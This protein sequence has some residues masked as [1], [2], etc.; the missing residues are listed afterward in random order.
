MASRSTRDQLEDVADNCRQLG[1]RLDPVTQRVRSRFTVDT[2]ALAAL[3][4]S[5][6]LIILIDLF[7]R[8]GDLEL[9]YTDDG[10]YPLVAYETTYSR[11][12]GLSLHAASGDLWFQQMMFVLAG[13]FAVALILGYRT[14]LVAI[15]SF[16]LLFSL[17]ARNP[18]VLNG[19]DRLLRV[20]LLVALVTPLGERWSIDAL[21]RGTA[22]TTVTSV[23]TAALLAQPLAVFTTNAVLKH[24]G[25]TWYAG[26]A[27][28]IAFASDEMTILLGNH[29]TAYPT[30]LEVLTWAWV[31]LLAGSVVFLLVTTGR[32]RAFFALVYIGSFAGL[33]VSVSV[34][35]F[36]LVLTA[37]VFPFLSTPFWDTLTRLVP[38][39]LLE[40]R[41]SAAVLGPL[42]RSPLERRLLASVR[43]RGHDSAASF[44]VEFGRSLLTVV[45][46]LLLVWILLF[47]VAH[48]TDVEVP[49]GLDYDQLDDQRWGLYAP[50]PSETYGWFVAEAE[51]DS[52]TTVDAFE[53]GDVVKDRPPDAAQEYDTFRER[54]FMETVRT[55][56][57]TDTNNVTAENYAEWACDRSNEVH[58]GDVEQ[59]TLYRMLQSSPV[60]G[61]YEDPRRMTIIEWD[62]HS[63]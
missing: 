56:G 54:K 43:R 10:V 3:R 16:V 12:T 42:A 62:C 2:R 49:A 24:R 45:G 36:S 63:S 52:D 5:L 19:G 21:R 34:G 39:R 48:V 6:G 53:G 28:Q 22:R 17:H 20:L 61:E 8:A 44:T 38:D 30:L 37:A 59:V 18:A 57:R 29:L 33:L 40:R 55:S 46:V 26:E 15:V 58:G 60:D 9:Y 23:A 31:T 47:N 11:F 14:R 25:D 50:D 35:L 4:I 32:V 51:L 41:P 13:L 27:L 1:R 7:H